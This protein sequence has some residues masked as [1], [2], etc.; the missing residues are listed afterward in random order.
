[1]IKDPSKRLGSK[2]GVDDILAHSWFQDIDIAKY[3]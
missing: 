3:I 2:N 1:M